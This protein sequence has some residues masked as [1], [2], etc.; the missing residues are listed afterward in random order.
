MNIADSIIR[1]RLKNVYFIW[2]RGKTTI[3]GKLH[4]KYGFY[5]YSTDLHR[6]RLRKE[7]DPSDQP[8]MCRDYEKEYGVSDFWELPREVIADREQHFVE[9]MTPM[10]VVDL[11]TLAE[12]H[13]VVICEGDIDYEA[14]ARVATHMVHLRRNCGTA[15]DW[16]GRPDHRNSLDSLQKRTDLS[17]AAKNAIIENARE[18]VSADDRVLPDWVTRLNIQNIDW[19]DNTSIEQTALEVEK[20]FGFGGQNL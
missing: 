1:K 18:T 3:A 2:G 5:I 13:K 4:N 12:R 8:Y 11:I 19:D 16:F 7:A 15:F 9:E 10:M 20:V 6:D 17:D 14:I